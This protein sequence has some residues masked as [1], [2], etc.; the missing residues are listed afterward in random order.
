[1][2]NYYYFFL[3]THT[4]AHTHYTYIYRIETLFYDLLSLTVS[5]ILRPYTWMYIIL[6]SYHIWSFY[7]YR[8]SPTYSG[9]PY[10]GVKAIHVQ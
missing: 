10:D 7:V 5:E 8:P 3:T 9:L 2:L 1:M 6:K 4:Y